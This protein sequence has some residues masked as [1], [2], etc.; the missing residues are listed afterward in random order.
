MALLA[1]AVVGIATGSST[2][3][4]LSGASEPAVVTGS[5]LGFQG[6]AA[7]SPFLSL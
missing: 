4:V 5:W 7:L 2:A 6:T 3:V 1:T